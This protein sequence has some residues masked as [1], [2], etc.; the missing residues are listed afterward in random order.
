M[1]QGLTVKEDLVEAVFQKEDRRKKR[2]T[3]SV[4]INTHTIDGAWKTNL[5]VRPEQ[6][7]KE[8]KGRAIDEEE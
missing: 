4:G 6:D 5:E 1:F 3:K 8:L 2:N 7:W